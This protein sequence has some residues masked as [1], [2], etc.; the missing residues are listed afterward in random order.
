MGHAVVHFELIGPNPREAAKF[1]EELFGWHTQTWDEG[2]ENEYI[3]VDTHAGSGI[4]GG[5]GASRGGSPKVTFYAEADDLQAM[6]D[7]AES[8]GGTTVMPVTEIPMV[9]FAHLS[10]PQGNV[11]GLVKGAEP[12]QEAP[13]VSPGDNPGVSWFEVLGPDP[14]ALWGFYKELFGWSIKE[15]EG[16]GFVYGEVDTGSERGIPGGIGATFDGQGHTNVYAGV[17]DLQ[18]YVER[19][20]SLGGKTLMP[21]MEVSGGTSIAMLADPQGTW[22]GLFKSSSM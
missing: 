18:K 22:F 12:G 2:G 16:E 20:E 14:K 19:A 13:G 15:S 21:P 5:I 8:L 3:L 10:D 7:K 4:N 1:Y 9:T 17:D 11:V 6:L